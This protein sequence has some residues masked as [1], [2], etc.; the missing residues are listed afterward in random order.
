MQT[1]HWYTVFSG[2]IPYAVR[3]PYVCFMQNVCYV[4]RRHQFLLFK[5]RLYDRLAHSYVVHFVVYLN[6][7]MDCRNR[8]YI[9]YQ[10]QNTLS[11]MIVHVPVHATNCILLIS[12]RTKTSR[13]LSETTTSA[14]DITV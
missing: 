5:S 13:G 10:T 11:I 12:L 1:P 8:F 7:N 14:N 6:L 9:M 3:K 4:V 2:F